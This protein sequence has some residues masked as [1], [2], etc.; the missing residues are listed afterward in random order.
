M[1][2]QLVLNLKNS[3]AVIFVSQMIAEFYL[4]ALFRCMCGAFVSSL[5]LLL[6][7][8]FSFVARSYN[9][10]RAEVKLQLERVTSLL[11]LF[12]VCENV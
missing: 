5:S 9:F 12:S 11:I 3:C 2:E 4:Q 10:S 6:S 7:Q 8:C 1:L